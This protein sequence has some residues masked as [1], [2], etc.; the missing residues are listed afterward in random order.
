MFL[1]QILASASII[2]YSHAVEANANTH[3]QT[4]ID[5]SETK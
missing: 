4:V 1:I 5:S 2:Q 3:T